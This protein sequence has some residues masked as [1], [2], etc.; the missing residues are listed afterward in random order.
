MASALDVGEPRAEI[1]RYLAER[2]KGISPVLR[3]E[4]LRQEA[5]KAHL[6]K[7]HGMDHTREG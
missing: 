3:G 2:W 5:F 7:V 1:E 6:F 4:Q